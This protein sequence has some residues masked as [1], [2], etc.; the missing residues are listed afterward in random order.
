MPKAHTLV[1]SFGDNTV[2]TAKWTAYGGAQEVNQRVEIPLPSNTVNAYAGFTSVLYYDL[3]GSQVVVELVRALRTTSGSETYLLLK[4]ATGDRI[5]YKVQ[6]GLF[7]ASKLPSGA[8]S[9]THLG[10]Q[11]YDPA[12]HR[13]MRIREQLGVLYFDY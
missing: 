5:Y 8:G 2:D 6:D 1:D 7:Y 4:N 12:R 10:E 13:W 11:P 9:S 3:T